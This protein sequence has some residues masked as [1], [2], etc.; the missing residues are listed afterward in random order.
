MTIKELR[1]KYNL[2]QSALA[3]AL[4]VTSNAISGIEG[5]RIKLSPKMTAKIKEVYGEELTS[6]ATEKASVAA[7]TTPEKKTTTKKAAEVAGTVGDVV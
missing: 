2:T 4:G 3:K 5:G 7:A 1:E 6:A